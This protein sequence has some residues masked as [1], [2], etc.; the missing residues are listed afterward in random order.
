M[1]TLGKLLATLYFYA[2]PHFGTTYSIRGTTPDGESVLVV[3]RTRKER[4][5]WEIAV[6]RYT[7]HYLMVLGRPFFIR[8]IQHP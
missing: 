4:E 2:I 1:E 7:S 6:D 8:H 5:L 3:C